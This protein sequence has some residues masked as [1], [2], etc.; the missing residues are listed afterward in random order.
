MRGPRRIL[1]G[2][3]SKHFLEFD[4]FCTY[5]SSLSEL[6]GYFSPAGPSNL[7]VA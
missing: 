1:L 4:I 3:N 7:A 2:L 6:V 5:L